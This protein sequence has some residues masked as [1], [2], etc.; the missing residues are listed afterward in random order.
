MKPV[1]RTLMAG[2][3]L[4]ALSLSAQDKPKASPAAKP[5]KFKVSAQTFVK[6]AKWATQKT[7]SRMRAAQF[8]VVKIVLIPDPHYTLIVS[9]LTQLH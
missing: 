4:L 8:G 5:E 3:A 1:I 2:A 9:L 6:P 7:A